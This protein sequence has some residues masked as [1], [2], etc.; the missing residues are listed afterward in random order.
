MVEIISPSFSL[1][2]FLFSSYLPSEKADWAGISL[3]EGC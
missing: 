1:P 3:E 2:P